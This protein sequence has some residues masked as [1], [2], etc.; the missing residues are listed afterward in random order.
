MTRPQTLYSSISS[1]RLET[2]VEPTG[3]VW[4][5]VAYVLILLLLVFVELRAALITVW[6]PDLTSAET[7]GVGNLSLEGET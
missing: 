5:L 2:A 4:R 6:K 7:E 1:L 3:L